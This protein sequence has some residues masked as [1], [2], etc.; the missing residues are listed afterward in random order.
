MYLICLCHL[1]RVLSWK[2]HLKEE[3]PWLLQLTLYPVL[4]EGKLKNKKIPDC[5]NYKKTTISTYFV[6]VYLLL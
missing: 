1:A 6:L 5:V 2:Q 3:L 4:G